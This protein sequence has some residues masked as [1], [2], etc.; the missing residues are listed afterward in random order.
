MFASSN[1]FNFLHLCSILILRIKI[2]TNKSSYKISAGFSSSFLSFSRIPQEN[3]A[4]LPQVIA[5]DTNRMYWNL[6]MSNQNED[7]LLILWDFHP[8]LF[9]S[10]WWDF[11]LRELIYISA[12]WGFLENI[13]FISRAFN[14]S[15]AEMESNVYKDFCWY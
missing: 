8:Q 6:F 3:D 14:H 5:Y 4:T 15:R 12:V 9:A 1:C 11:F 13:L 7:L 10:F 2:E